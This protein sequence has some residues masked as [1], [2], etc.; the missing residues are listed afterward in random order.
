[1]R[2]RSPLLIFVFASPLSHSRGV[3][4]C[5][6]LTFPCA[7]G[8]C[9]ITQR[10]SEG[11][12]ATPRAAMS[13]ISGFYRADRTMRPHS[14]IPLS[15]IKR[16]DGWCDD[17]GHRLYNRQITLPFKARH[18]KMWRDDHAYDIVLDLSWNRSPIRRLRGSAIFLH[19]AKDGFPPTEG[20]IA[21]RLKDMKILLGYIGRKVRIIV[22]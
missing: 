8:K 15:L 1:M 2:S 13:I 9:G 22:W 11:D 20:C 14:R 10:K 18:E 12:G 19:L 7:L 21:L 4:K 17:P 6:N 5:A 3:L 16:H